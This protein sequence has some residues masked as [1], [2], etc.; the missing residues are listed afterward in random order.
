MKTNLSIALIG[1]AAA[2]GTSTLA[3]AQDVETRGYIGASIGQSKF[4]DACIGLPAAGFVGSCDQKDTAWKV[5]GGYQFNRHIGVELGYTD[6]GE[7]NAA[8]TIRGVPVTANAEAKAIE[9]VAVGTL[10]INDRFSVYAKAGMYRWDIDARAVVGGV[11]TGIGD[12]GN[13]F[14]YGF[15]LNFHINRNVAIRAEWQ[16]Y[17]EVGEDTTTGR[18]DVNVMSAG[19]VFKF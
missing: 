11:P 8:G 6:L 13:D 12:K 5:F 4:K 7:A 10:P 9:I 18:S 1:L 15:G 3:K 19:V 17:N 16:R 2:M 14:T